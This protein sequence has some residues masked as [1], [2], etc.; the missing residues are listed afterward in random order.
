MRSGG[1]MVTEVPVHPHSVDVLG[2]QGRFE[3][4]G[5]EIQRILGRLL[6]VNLQHDVHAAPEVQAQFEACG[7]EIFFPPVRDV[8]IQGRGEGEPRK[9]E[10]KEHKPDFKL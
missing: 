4:R 2:G 6:Q 8:V 5:G 7:R 10:Q 1:Y 3:I 9:K